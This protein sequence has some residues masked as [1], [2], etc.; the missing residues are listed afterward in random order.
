MKYI[1]YILF[2]FPIWVTAQ[3]YKYIGTENGLSNRRIFS[4]QKDAQ[5]YM[6]FLTDEGM[7]RYNGQ[8]RRI[9]FCLLISQLLSIFHFHY[10]SYY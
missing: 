2:F 10:L 5:G 3:T 7:D 9:I 8:G 6:W 4:I 1:I